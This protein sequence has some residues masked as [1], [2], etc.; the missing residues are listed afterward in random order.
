[1]VP[2]VLKAQHEPQLAWFLMGVTAPALTQSTLSA[3]VLLWYLNGLLVLV[4]QQRS[5]AGKKLN[6]KVSGKLQLGSYEVRCVH[7]LNKTDLNWPPV[8]GCRPRR[9]ARNSS[10]VRS[11]NWLTAICSASPDQRTASMAQALQDSNSTPS[12]C[13]PLRCAA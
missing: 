1:M 3:A 12:S 11:A 13:G 5:S 10:G 2:V 4:L 8:V 6:P 9:V 7:R